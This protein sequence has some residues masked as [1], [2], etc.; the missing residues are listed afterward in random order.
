MKNKI[1]F[2]FT[3]CIQQKMNDLIKSYA[4]QIHVDP[5]RPTFDEFVR[6]F[7]ELNSEEI[8]VEFINFFEDCQKIN[9][10]EDEFCI[11]QNK[12]SDY[13]LCSN[14]F[15]SIKEL[16]KNE[17]FKMLTENVDYIIR[18]FKSSYIMRS[19]EEY[20]FT[21]RAFKLILMRTSKTITYCEY[22]LLIDR[23]MTYYCDLQKKNN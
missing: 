7:Q 9:K 20:I 3:V 15:E 4:Y 11:P 16:L 19:H 6:Y 22:L 21:R 8:P 17:E 13:A 18:D 2:N 10:L 14:N 12:L 1:D 23:L 5:A